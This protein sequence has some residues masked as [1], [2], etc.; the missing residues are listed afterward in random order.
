MKKFFIFI[1]FFLPI[2][3]F[4]NEKIINSLKDGKKIVFI[5]HAIA[6]GNGDPDNFD[7]TDCS[8]QRNL[9]D[10][11]RAQSKIIGEFFKSNK[12]LFDKVLTSE[13][14]RCK[15]TGIIAFGDIETFSAL[16]SFYDQRFAKNKYKQ[17]QN[18]KK[19]IKNRKSKKNLILITHYVVILEILNL[20]TS[21]GEIIISN[22]N[23]ELIGNIKTM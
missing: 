9:N 13:W 4:S 2:N 19:Y 8:T 7:I 16:N 6:P 15:D 5:R 1:I 14:C 22:K 21:S 10:K 17:I 11:G 12:I 3:S 18:L 20:G 23:F